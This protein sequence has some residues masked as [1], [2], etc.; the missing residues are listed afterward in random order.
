MYAFKTLLAIYISQPIVG[1]LL[2]HK[3]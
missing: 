2:A 3:F 1:I